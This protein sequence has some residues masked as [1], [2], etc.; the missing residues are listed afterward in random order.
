M[1]KKNIIN[2]FIKFD[3]SPDIKMLKGIISKRKLKKI[4]EGIFKS[5]FKK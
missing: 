2:D 4:F 5:L 3:L 1:I